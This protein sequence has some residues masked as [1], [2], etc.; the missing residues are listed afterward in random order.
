[1]STNEIRNEIARLRQLIMAGKDYDGSLTARAAE[2]L[3]L[4]DERTA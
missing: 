4:L 3:D 1:M 2:L